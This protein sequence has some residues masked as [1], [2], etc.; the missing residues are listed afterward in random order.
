M[1]LRGAIVEHTRDFRGT[2]G[3]ANEGRVPLSFIIKPDAVFEGGFVALQN[4]GSGSVIA[5]MR[6]M[7]NLSMKVTLIILAEAF[8]VGLPIP[9]VGISS[10]HE[11]VAHGNSLGHDR[12]WLAALNP[13]RPSNAPPIVI[14][15]SFL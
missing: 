5:P 6:E 7:I 2:V 11:E 12:Q 15:D 4:G 9:I 13:A 10:H 3:G 14:F 1:K 8:C